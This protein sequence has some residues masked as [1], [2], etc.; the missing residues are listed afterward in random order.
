MYVCLSEVL[1]DRS[2]LACDHAVLSELVQR[3]WAA[4]RWHAPVKGLL[5]W[6]AIWLAKR[7]TGP[8]IQSAFAVDAGLLVGVFRGKAD[9]LAGMIFCAGETFWIHLRQLKATASCSLTCC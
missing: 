6:V 7:V 8:R 2:V 9:V 4:A 3:L 5:H 1:R